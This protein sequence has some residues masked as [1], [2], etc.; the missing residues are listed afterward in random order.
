MRTSSFTTWLFRGTYPRLFLPIIAI[1]VAVTLVRYHFLLQAEAGEAQERMSLGLKHLEHYLVPQLVAADADTDKVRTLLDD[2]IAFN[3]SIEGLTWQRADDTLVSVNDAEVAPVPAWFTGLLGMERVDKTVA[4]ALEDGT[5]ARLRIALN[6]QVEADRVWHTIA[7]Q[8]RI[9]ALNIVTIFVL[10]TLLLRANTRMLSRLSQATEQFS[11]G[12]LSTRMAE[13]GTLE[14]RAVAKTFNGMAAQI[15]GLVTSLQQHQEQQEAQLHFTRQLNNALPLPVFVRSVQGACLSVNAAW[16]QLFGRSAERVI[17]ARMTGDFAESPARSPGQER[18]L[19]ARVDR[20]VLVRNAQNVLREMVYFSAPFTHTDGTPAGT[21]GTLVDITDRKLAQR[22]LREEKERAE[23]TLSSIGDGVITTDARGCVQSLNDAAYFLTGFSL[24]Q[25]RGKALALVFRLDPSGPGAQELN[26]AMATDGPVFARQQVLLHR[27]GERYA[28][29]YTASP[30]RKPSGIAMGTVLVFRDV[31]E[32]REL[33]QQLYWQSRHD[34][35]TGLDNRAALADRLGQALLLARQEAR[36]LAVCLLDLDHFQSVN[37]RFGTALG[38]RLLKDVAARLLGLA[39][40]GDAVARLGGD[41]FALLLNGLEDEQAIRQRLSQVLVRLAEPY[42]VGERLMHTSASVGVAIFPQDD[43]TPDLLLRHADQAMWQAKQT[44]R[45]CLHI[46]DARHDQEVQTNF[47]RHARIA[48]ALKRGELELYYQPKVHLFSGAVLGLEALVRWQHPEQGLLDPGHFLPVIENSALS[49]ELGEWALRE[50]LGQMKRW[51]TQGYRWSVGVNIAAAHFHRADFAARLRS[52]LS[53]F[54]MILP[55]QLE[56]EVLESTALAD[57]E[58]MR[59]VMQECQALGVRFALDDFGTGFSS[60]SYLKA[61]PA[62]TLKIDQSFVKGVM[63][64]RDD[65]T[66]VGAIVSLAKA[67]ER[68][69]VAEGVET[70]AQGQRLMAL[71][72][73]SAQGYAIARPMP[74]SDV[75]GFVQGYKNIF[76]DPTGDGVGAFAAQI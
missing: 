63:E 8:L 46:F 58:Q 37:D 19:A 40:P 41:E 38:D 32:T 11:S 13:T 42:L 30:I 17:G 22:A 20:E 35:L 49:V 52:I 60:L 54:P 16:E 59:T 48:L 67:F 15:Q 64:H 55:S 74:A 71:G 36:P 1:V 65:M 28:V 5:L 47:S 56:L 51:G 14:A 57:L 76:A 6:P 26:H 29:E 23:V 10:L 53:E 43:A 70:I 50:A 73:E 24:E 18:R 34:P 25:A 69:V 4:L 7:T 75:A 3:T 68:S 39:G 21:I 12:E 9:S 44:G 66:L 61:L 62:E 27:S 45:N 72:C 31:T 33:Q 2:E